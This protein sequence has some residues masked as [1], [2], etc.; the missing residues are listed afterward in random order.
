MFSGRNYISSFFVQLGNS[1]IKPYKEFY[2]HTSFIN[3]NFNK[4]FQI[5]TEN[6]LW[7]YFGL[8]LE[9]LQG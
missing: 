8:C 2:V 4:Y 6:I 5:N 9:W 3:L 1:L 7:D